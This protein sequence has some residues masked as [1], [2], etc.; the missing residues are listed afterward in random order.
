MKCRLFLF[1]ALALLVATAIHVQAAGPAAIGTN[2]GIAIDLKTQLEKGLRARRPV[3]F[4]YIAEVVAMVEVGAIPKSL[5]DSSFL[6]A[7]KQR[8]RQLQ[9]FQF[10]LQRQANRIGVITP[11][12]ANQFV[13]PITGTLPG[14]IPVSK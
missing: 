7:R 13:N 6:W 10:A 9:Y 5:V 1:V 14:R 3:E 11:S 8:S 12:L 2:P 4:A